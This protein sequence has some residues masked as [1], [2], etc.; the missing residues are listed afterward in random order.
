MNEELLRKLAEIFTTSED[1]DAL[2]SLI[3]ERKNHLMYRAFDREFHFGEKSE[4]GGI[5]L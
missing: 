1:L 2:K 4:H 3:D 5:E